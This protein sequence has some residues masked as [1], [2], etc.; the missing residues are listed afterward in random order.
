MFYVIGKRLNII[1]YILICHENC[2]RDPDIILTLCQRKYRSCPQKCI[3]LNQDLAEITV[4]SSFFKCFKSNETN[5]L[6]F[7]DKKS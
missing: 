5:R 3:T 2:L 7:I 4:D 1:Q 6:P